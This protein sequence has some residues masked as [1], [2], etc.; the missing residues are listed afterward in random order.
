MDKNKNKNYKILF[1]CIGVLFLSFFSV[2]AVDYLSYDE[3]FGVFGVNFKNLYINKLNYKA[4]EEMQIS[5]DLELSDNF[6]MHPFVDGR[7]VLEVIREEPYKPYTIMDEIVVAENVNFKKESKKHFSLSYKIPDTFPAGKY[8]IAYFNF[9]DG[10]NVGGE[11]SVY[12]MY[13]TSFPF[14]VES[15]SNNYIE[16]NQDKVYINDFRYEFGTFFPEFQNGEELTVK[17]F[18]K[19]YGS[20]RDVTIKYEVFVWN[21]AKHKSLKE[22][23]NQG[24][25]K[26]EIKKIFDYAESLIKE[27]TITLAE[28]SERIVSY[29]LGKLPVGTYV[30]KITATSDVGKSII[31]LRVPVV[32]DLT[33][34]VFSSISDFPLLKDQETSLSVC[35]SQATRSLAPYRILIAENESEAQQPPKQPTVNNKIVLTLY[36]GENIFFKKEYDVESIIDIRCIK[37]P[38][39]ASEKITKAN[40]LTELYDSNG[41]LNDI[42]E[43]RFDYS[44]FEPEKREFNLDAS[45]GFGY[46]EYFVSLKNELGDNLKDVVNIVVRDA[47]GKIVD[48]QTNLLIEGRYSKKVYLS[49]GEYVVQVIL[50]DGTQKT[51]NRVKVYEEMETEETTKESI[52]K[53]SNFLTML[54][55]A[56]IVIAFLV[57]LYIFVFNPKKRLSSKKQK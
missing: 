4:G 17:A 29:N 12:G 9:M 7:V 24:I 26:G 1:L 32:G 50:S 40:L 35:F 11:E 23:N 56:I 52:G 45:S 41:I 22:L 16:F 27:E 3:V 57:V 38:F 5:F 14:T 48:V 34:I 37:V 43:T 39:T 8:R 33:R 13:A 51:T 28:N 10:Y 36:E 30:V 20:S 2:K 31:L 42:E 46:L 53:Q 55:A 25:L 44:L 19:N 54:I 18:L 15:K 49:P 21:E 47:G 6:K